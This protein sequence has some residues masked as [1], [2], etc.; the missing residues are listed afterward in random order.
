LEVTF[1]MTSKLL[2]VCI[3]D[4]S[5]NVIWKGKMIDVIRGKTC[6]GSLMATSKNLLMVKIFL[7]GKSD[8]NKPKASLDR[9]Y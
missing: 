5:N 3:L 8:V 1:T 7:F 6:C 9:Q 2:N 4:G